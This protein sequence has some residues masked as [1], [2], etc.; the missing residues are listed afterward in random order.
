MG[1]CPIPRLEASITLQTRNLFSAWM[2]VL[3][4]AHAFREEL[5]VAAAWLR[6]HAFYS[7]DL[8]RP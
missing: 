3:R 8:E 7:L 2:C 4:T 5:S 6:V 1:A